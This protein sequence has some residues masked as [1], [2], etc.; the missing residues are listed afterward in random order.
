MRVSQRRHRRALLLHYCFLLPLSLSV[1]DRSM[2]PRRSRRLPRDADEEDAIPVSLPSGSWSRSIVV[3][4]TGWLHIAPIHPVHARCCRKRLYNKR[5]PCARSRKSRGHVD[6]RQTE[7]ILARAA[8]EGHRTSRPLPPYRTEDGPREG[9]H[10]GSS[11]RGEPK[12]VF[13]HLN[14]LPIWSLRSF[15]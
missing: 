13:G 5:G 8:R 10:P 7:H 4:E 11:R 1:T 15:A 12:A 2:I 9:R 6:D 3:N 14:S